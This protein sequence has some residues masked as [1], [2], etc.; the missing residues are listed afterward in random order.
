V[1]G[2]AIITPVASVIRYIKPFPEPVVLVVGDAIGVLP[3]ITLTTQ[4]L[5]MMMSSR[6][7]PRRAASK[8][9]GR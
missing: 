5:A 4:V 1:Q 6:A 2:Y 7:R 9:K 3:R 8:T